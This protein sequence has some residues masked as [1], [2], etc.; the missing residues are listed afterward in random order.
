MPGTFGGLHMRR[1][2]IL[3][4]LLAVGALVAWTLWHW[5]RTV[6]TTKDPWMA[7]PERAAMVIEVPDAWRAWDRFTHTSQLWSALEQVGSLAAVG[8]LMARTTE[9]AENDAALRHAL[10]DV[11]VVIA[12]ARTGNKTV[13]LLLT[14]APNTTDGIPLR[15][16][17]ELLKADEATM[18]ALQR[19]DVVQVRPDTALA[20]LSLCIQ[21]GLWL[22]ATSPAMMDEAL[23]QLKKGTSVA[24]DSLLNEA[25]R[26]LGGGSDA[27]VLVHMDRMRTVLHTWFT[28][29]ALEQYKTPNG[30]AALDVRSR[31]DALLLSGLLLPAEADAALLSLDHQGTG[32][33][34]L[35][36]WLPKEVCAWDVQ[37]VSDPER[38]LRERAEATDADRTELGPTLFH[39]V[40]GSMAV[41]YGA[42]GDSTGSPFWALF[43]TDDP[44]AA[45]VQLEGACP[46]GSTCDTA[47]HRGIRLTHLPIAAAYERL[48]GA[49]YA[50]LRDPWWCALG[51]V[52]VVATDA[53]ALRTVIDA[54]NDGR[55]LAEDARTTGWTERISSTASRTMRWDIARCWTHVTTQLEPEH[56]TEYQGSHGVWQRLGGLS[57]QLAPALHGRTALTIGLQHAPLEERSSGVLWSTAL[58]KTCTRIPDIVR[59]HTNGTREVL[60]QD[61]EHLIHLLGS[62]GKELWSYPLDGPILGEVQQVD[63]F[64]N[65]KLQLLFN[66]ASRIYV[67]DRNGKDVGGFPVSLPVKTQAPLAAFDYDGTREYRLLLPLTDG[68]ILN[69]GLDGQVVKGWAPPQLRTGASNSISHVRIGNKDHLL[70]TADDGSLL[71]LDRKGAERERPLLELGPAP[72]I[73]AVAPGLELGA[74]KLIWRNNEGGLMEGALNEKAARQLGGPAGWYGLGGLADDGEHDVMHVRGDTLT[75]THGEKTVFEYHLGEALGLPATCYQPTKTELVYGISLPG[76]EQ[77]TLLDQAGRP[78]DGMPVQGASLFA[79][80]DLDLDGSLEWVTVTRDGRVIAYHVLGTGALP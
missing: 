76:R 32:R 33:N 20:D 10:S 16:F 54:W 27:H 24:A 7:V 46:P 64:Q 5:E 50:P 73:L 28:P 11:S 15:V 41:A 17:A 26:T 29:N 31:P 63:R 21:Q 80:G 65:G 57:I 72:T 69:Y 61:D 44:D 78:L 23:L 13:D 68:R 9:R 55:T 53:T 12:M 42:K 67:I 43:Q 1:V 49:A 38:F 14:C 59:N 62:A 18:L 74:T 48:L 37:Q 36:R 70:V 60:V 2:L 45:Q 47:N 58:N 66:T 40:Q 4:L 52:I 3:V 71:L 25:R 77:V 22:L 34:D 35:A 8:R 19:G 30:W 39:W 6:P 75:I 56:A 79:M 51:D